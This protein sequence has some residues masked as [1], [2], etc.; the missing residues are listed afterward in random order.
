MVS[1][2][3]YGGIM[4]IRKLLSAYTDAR[5]YTVMDKDMDGVWRL[6][7]RQ[8]CEPI[9]EFCKVAKDKPKDP[10]FWHVAE[11]PM[12]VI[13]QWMRDGSLDDEKHVRRW[14]NDPANRDFRIHEGTV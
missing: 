7:T 9:V 1:P 2:L 14:L 3:F 10:T 4:S 8:D 5:K 12:S 11:I 6:E 13:G